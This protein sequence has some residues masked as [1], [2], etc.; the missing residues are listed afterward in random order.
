MAYLILAKNIIHKLDWRQI[1]YQLTFIPR[2]DITA[3]SMLPGMK[4]CLF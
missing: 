2:L 1:F 3:F 4:N